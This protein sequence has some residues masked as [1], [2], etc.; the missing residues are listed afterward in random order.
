ME[1]QSNRER[2]IYANK[3][4]WSHIDEYECFIYAHGRQIKS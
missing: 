2:C 3:D 1:S 4:K